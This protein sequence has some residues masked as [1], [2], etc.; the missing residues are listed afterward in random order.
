L[1]RELVLSKAPSDYLYTSL[2]DEYISLGQ[3]KNALGVLRSRAS[4]F[5]FSLVPEDIEL[6]SCSQDVNLEHDISDFLEA[7]I[8]K[9][10]LINVNDTTSISLTKDVFHAIGSLQQELGQNLNAYVSYEISC[11][12]P[13]TTLA[14]APCDLPNDVRAKLTTDE[15][16]QAAQL[17]SDWK[18]AHV[19]HISIYR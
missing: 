8:A 3:C 13:Q 14:P 7:K 5:G 1:L 11:E 4:H 19:R 12:L 18:D 9:I 10:Q 17:A 16:R 15:I 2:A 6:T